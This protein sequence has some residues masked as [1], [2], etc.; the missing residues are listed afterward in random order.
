MVSYINYCRFGS[1][2]HPREYCQ[3]SGIRDVSTLLHNCTF[4]TRGVS[5]GKSEKK[6]TGGKQK[7]D[8]VK[9]QEAVGA[10]PG[11][12][13]LFEVGNKLV[14][15]LKTCVSSQSISIT[16]FPIVPLPS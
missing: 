13:I 2:L 6:G 15:S 10:E 11:D 12:Y 16:N 8:S 1:H 14:L 4:Y 9:M 5:L 7:E 3:D